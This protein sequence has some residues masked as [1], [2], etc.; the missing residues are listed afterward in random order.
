[1]KPESRWNDGKGYKKNI[2]F[3]RA[4]QKYGWDNFEHKII[5]QNLCKEEAQRLEIEFI[6]LHNTTNI[7]NGYNVSLGGSIPS[8][9]T[10]LK[11]SKSRMGKYKG[12]NNSFYGRKHSIETRL[13]LSNINKGKNKGSKNYNAQKVICLNTKE[14]YD[15]V[16]DASSSLNIDESS[17]VKC[18]KGK[19][20]YI[21]SKTDDCP[22]V[23][24]YYDDYKTLSE[25]DVIGLIEQGTTDYLNT[26]TK[27]VCLN[28]GEEFESIAQATQ[29]Y[30]INHT[31]HITKCCQGKQLSAGKDPITGHKLVWVYFEEYIKLSEQD[32]N[33]ILLN[34]KNK[35]HGRSKR[36]KCI[37]NNVVYNS[38][39][40]CS[41][42]LGISKD[43]IRRSLLKN[44]S[45]LSGYTFIY[46]D[47][48]LK[49]NNENN[50]KNC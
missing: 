50:N 48:K 27:V 15:C 13:Y 19:Q 16:R 45:T 5:S 8:K 31:S 17:I 33:N 9:D 4:I 3:W 10:K 38:I 34:A 23:W 37:N 30:K 1:M 36:I 40:D 49:S 28:T 25:A 18:C 2:H 41:K 21:L 42:I 7:K 39:T 46:E 35:T 14:V 20:R 32:V 12:E 43:A 29:Q 6:K 26:T 22:L 24:R 47:V 11:I 44:V